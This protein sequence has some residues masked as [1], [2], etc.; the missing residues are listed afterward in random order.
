M[1][2]SLR[3]AVRCGLLTAIL[4]LGMLASQPVQAQRAGY[5]S[6]IIVE[7]PDDQDAEQ[8]AP[9]QA[10]IKAARQKLKANSRKWNKEWAIRREQMRRA[11]L[12]DIQAFQD[13]KLQALTTDYLET[14]RSDQ[15][16]LSWLERLEK[17]REDTDKDWISHN[18]MPALPGQPEVILAAYTMQDAEPEFCDNPDECESDRIVVSGSRI[19]RAP[20][21]TNVQSVGV[22]E[23]DIIKQIGHYLLTLQDGRIFA[24]D[25]R[26][27]KL[28]D[29]I[30]VYRKDEDGDSLGADW[31]DEML[32]QDNHILI[33]AYSYSDEA[34]ELSVFKLDEASGK[35]SPA[36][37]FLISSDD[38]YDG[39]DYASRIIGDKLVLY[40]PYA[41]NPDDRD[42]EADG[43]VKPYIRRWLPADEREEERRKG[44][45]LFSARDIYKPLLATNN[46]VIHTISVCPLGPVKL[47]KDLDCRTTGFLGAYGAQM[48]VNANNIYL[49]NSLASEVEQSYWRDACD[50]D[51]LRQYPQQDDTAEGALY[52]MSVRTGDV[53]VVGV[54]GGVYD[55]YSMDEYRGRLR[56]LSPQESIAC[57][58]TD[59]DAEGHTEHVALVDFPLREFG[60]QFRQLPDR[61]YAQ[62]P[63]PMGGYIVQNRFNKNW[64]TYGGKGRYW[65]LPYDEDEQA[66][67]AENYVVTVP[68]SAPKTAQTLPL[69]HSVAR[70][71]LVGE[72]VVVTGYRDDSGLSISFLKMDDTPR[73]SDRLFL[74]SRYETEKRSHAFNYAANTDGTAIMGLPT[75]LQEDDSGRYVYWSDRS[76]LSFVTVTAEGKLSDAGALIGTSEEDSE[77]HEDYDCEVSCIDW[78]GN[79]RPIF[80]ADQ[81]F[82]LMDTKLVEAELVDGQIKAK[83]SVDMTGVVDGEKHHRDLDPEDWEDEEETST[84]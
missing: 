60:Q 49:W 7:E 59:S 21:V 16:L 33:T 31:Y 38:Y 26:T 61:A 82:G 84:E 4:P 12:D 29:R 75:S 24:V 81:I 69:G 19:A 32:V 45:P 6:V 27:M 62:V 46:P 20:N 73:I 65:S 41:V 30:D 63:P 79:A 74:A 1:H 50:A 43:L 48:Y 72:D 64:L 76:D 28:T 71:E 67:A 44:K 66:Q 54:R 56:A 53:S 5:S 68:I 35:I 55:Q 18:S 25:T 3:F 14:F 78:Y 22:D 37:V 52:K 39:N 58:H 57:A 40:A 10:E 11:A 2:T 36:G 83:A 51:R 34:T 47:G 17:V 8:A 42:F 80:T 23:G 15:D 9:T 13:A 70:L 77:V